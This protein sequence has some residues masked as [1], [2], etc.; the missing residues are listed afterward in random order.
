MTQGSG[1]ECTLAELGK[2][3]ERESRFT[4]MVTMICTLAILGLAY[5]T[6]ASEINILPDL[7]LARVM[8]NMEALSVEYQAILNAEAKHSGKP[9]TIK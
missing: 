1:E 4:R 8:G 7:V 2:K 9:V 6:M 3:I 5:Y